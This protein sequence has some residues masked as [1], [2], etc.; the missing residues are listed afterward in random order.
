[1]RFKEC[2]FFTKA[3]NKKSV[4]ITDEEKLKCLVSE[5]YKELKRQ[6]KYEFNGTCSLISLFEHKDFISLHANGVEETVRVEKEN[7]GSNA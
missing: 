3:V 2:N 6:G 1:M 7:R 4:P 5:L